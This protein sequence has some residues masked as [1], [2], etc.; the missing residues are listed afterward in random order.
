MLHA[1]APGSPGRAASRKRSGAPPSLRVVPPAM[2][3]GELLVAIGLVSEAEVSAALEEQQLTSRRLGDILVAR[4]ALS[5]ADLQRVLGAVPQPPATLDALGVDRGLVWDIFLKSVAAGLVDSPSSLAEQLCIP[6][7]LANQLVDE[8]RAQQLIEMRGGF[9]IAD[10]SF[11]LS[12]KGRA[13]ATIAQAQNGYVGPLPVS[14]DDYV[15]RVKQQT[16]RAETVPPSAVAAMYADM[17]TSEERLREIG[18][19]MNSGKAALIYG[20]AGNGKTSIAERM[21]RLLSSFIFVPHCF[22]VAGQ[23]IRVFDAS[24]HVP[25]RAADGPRRPSSL[26]VEGFDRR[27][28]AC[29][30]PFVVTGGELTLEMLD[31]GFNALSRFYEAPLQVKANNGVFLIDDFG[32][33]LVDPRALLNRWIVPMERRLD[34]LKL[35]SGKSFMLPFDALLLFS[36]NLVPED[37]MDPAFL[38]R[39]PYKILVDGPDEAQ[40]RRI[41]RSVLGKAGLPVEE[42]MIDEVVTRLRA[43]GLPLAAFQPRFLTD[44]FVDLRRYLGDAMITPGEMLDFAMRNL[45]GS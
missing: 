32:R 23:I 38:R 19:A 39:I 7:H 21:G 25:L 42:A 30:R 10:L 45:T 41:F 33:Q 29:R 35:Q 36:S 14:L 43:R 12:A 1:T 40:F 28:V 6:S 13:A 17:V 4:G 8:A 31:L 27:W 9:S 20:P 34:Y 3:I 11:G 18:A 44:Q 26:I 15:A 5:E 24:L 2:L 37:I 16:V 22:E